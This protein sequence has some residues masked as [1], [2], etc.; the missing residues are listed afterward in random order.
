VSI[1]LCARAGSRAD[2]HHQVTVS[3]DSTPRRHHPPALANLHTSA[4]QAPMPKEVWRRWTTAF[5]ELFE[6]A[7]YHHGLFCAINP[8]VVILG[9]SIISVSL[10]WPSL[11][12]LL[13]SN[14]A[15]YASLQ[16]DIWNTD[17]DFRFEGSP[18]T[19][20]STLPSIV[21][22]FRGRVVVCACSE[23]G[24]PDYL[25]PSLLPLS[26][27]SPSLQEYGVRVYSS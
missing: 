21:S 18:L 20:M 7:F 17:E 11:P 9:M 10:M 8:F 22:S 15:K 4:H 27:L 13:G 3:A 24:P 5:D 16:F 12:L 25:T 2:C 14:P 1:V 23:V 6:S 26:S 19:P